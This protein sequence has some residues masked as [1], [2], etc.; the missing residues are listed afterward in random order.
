MSR[1]DL[2]R[3]TIRA[4]HDS[5]RLLIKFLPERRGRVVA[6]LGLDE[7][8]VEA[9]LASLSHR[10]GTRGNGMATRTVHRGVIRGCF[11]RLE[12]DLPRV[13]VSARALAAE[14]RRAFLRRAIFRAPGR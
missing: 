3:Y 11:R 6:V 14:R 12:F 5:L 9:V 13:G 4:Y 7:L 8:H 10:K 2:T 1:A